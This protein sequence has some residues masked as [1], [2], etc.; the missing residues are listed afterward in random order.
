MQVSLSLPLLQPFS[1][2]CK[3]NFRA[4]QLASVSGKRCSARQEWAHGKDLVR[5]SVSELQGFNQHP[6]QGN[7]GKTLFVLFCSVAL[8][9]SREKKKEQTTNPQ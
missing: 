1:M 8:K 2:E 7:C 5:P 3:I 6:A 9:S 4:K